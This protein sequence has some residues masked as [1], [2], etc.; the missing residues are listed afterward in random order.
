[1]VQC[2]EI[3]LNPVAAA[4]ARTEALAF[5]KTSEQVK[6]EGTPDSLVP[7]RVFEGNRPSNT[8]LADR[9]TPETLG[10]DFAKHIEAVQ[11]TFC[12]VLG[13]YNPDGDAGLNKRQT[14]RLKQL[15]DYLHTRA[16]A[17]S[18]LNCWCRL[19]PSGLWQQP[20]YVR[21]QSFPDISTVMGADALAV[22]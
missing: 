11:P 20:H 3:K 8:I 21:K 7:H 9:L 2:V 15:S 14:A 22:A 18:C 5:G 10:N 4:V 6:A 17:G 13:R 1:M 19:S 16:K 12:K